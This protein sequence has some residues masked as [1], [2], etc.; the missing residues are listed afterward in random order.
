MQQPQEQQQ[1]PQ[2][3]SQEEQD[4]QQRAK[5]VQRRKWGATAPHWA[6]HSDLRNVQLA[7]VIERL[8]AQVRPG[9]AVLELAC[10]AG[11]LA[12]SVRARAGPTGSLLATDI[13]PEMVEATLQRAGS[14]S[15][16]SSGGGADADAQLAPLTARVMD[17]ES[18]DAPDASF[19]L[20][21]FAFGLMFCPSPERAAREALRVLRPGGRMAL[22][23]WSSNTYVAAVRTAVA[24]QA[25]LLG[26]PAPVPDPLGLGPFRLSKP[27][28]AEAAVRA[29]G[30]ADVTCETVRMVW[31]FPSTDA[32]WSMAV[33]QQAI[34]RVRQLLAHAAECLSAAACKSTYPACLRVRLPARLSA[35]WLP[36]ACACRVSLASQCLPSRCLPSSALAS[37]VSDFPACLLIATRPLLLQDL[38]PTL[39][40]DSMT[41]LRAALEGTLREYTTASG[42]LHCPT[43]VFLITGRRPL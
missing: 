4:E 39:P 3:L 35:L 2:Q 32:M 12:A 9:D 34:L 20:V 25:P 18:L 5:D 15:S 29:A 14:S 23:V 24:E 6:A 22:T 40:A 43:E 17:A 37:L 41:R 8:L 36:H 31:D 10:G 27:G 11:E 16:S 19:D 42:E 7:A 21:L 26:F 1:Q 38:A 33:A 13:A 28:V 30:F